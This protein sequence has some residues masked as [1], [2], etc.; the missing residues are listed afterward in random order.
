MLRLSLGGEV[1][2]SVGPDILGECLIHL[3]ISSR[4]FMNID[5]IP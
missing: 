5:G 3:E 2:T 4:Q 1:I